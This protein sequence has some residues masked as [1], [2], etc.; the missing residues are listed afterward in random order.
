MMFCIKEIVRY[1]HFAEN[2][3]TLSLIINSMHD[4]LGKY[5]L[6]KRPEL[7]N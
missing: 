7:K 5:L 1:V 6:L 4:F 3:I 2:S